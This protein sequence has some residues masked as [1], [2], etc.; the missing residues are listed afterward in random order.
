M[1]FKKMAAALF[2]AVIAGSAAVSTFDSTAVVAAA[3]AENTGITVTANG[4]PANLFRINWTLKDS[5][6]VKDLTKTFEISF[7]E[8]AFAG[9][10]SSM[11]GEGMVEVP[12]SYLVDNNGLDLVGEISWDCD[13]ILAYDVSTLPVILNP[14]TG[15][16]VA[17]MFGFSPGYLPITVLDGDIAACE[18]VNGEGDYYGYGY[19][20]GSKNGDDYIGSGNGVYSFV[21]SSIPK[22]EY[23]YDYATFSLYFAKPGTVKLTMKDRTGATEPTTPVEPT[24]STKEQSFHDDT[25][26]I[27]VDGSF[28]EG[29]SLKTEVKQTSDTKVSWDITPVTRTV[30]KFS[31]TARQP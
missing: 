19:H 23:E 4:S 15:L 30:T 9:N 29:T 16:P 25:T 28:P 6:Y 24:D 22:G 7:S 27:S 18:T 14:E 11:F 2:A 31:R 8:A 5:Y 3:D 10:E 26:D 21:R 12:I 20:L 1:K 13:A 17:D